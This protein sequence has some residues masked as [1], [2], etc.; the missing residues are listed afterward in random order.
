MRSTF[1]LGVVA[2]AATSISASADLTGNPTPWEGGELEV[3]Y[4][5]NSSSFVPGDT[6]FDAQAG[7]YGSVGAGSGVRGWNAYETTLSPGSA[8]FY[9]GEFIFVGG[10]DTA[11]TTVNFDFFEWDSVGGVPGAFVD[12][13]S[14]TLPQAGN[15]IWTITLDPGFAIPTLGYVEMFVAEDAGG[16]GQWFVTSTAPVVGTSLASPFTGSGYP[17]QG[18]RMVEGIVPAPGAIALLGFAGLAGSRR[19][20]G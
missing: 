7:P 20:R 8:S 14:V 1:L 18:L 16:L 2:I 12:G 9:L 5:G 11:D 10:V 4:L 3:R 19:R 17:S 6:V 13:F 15:F